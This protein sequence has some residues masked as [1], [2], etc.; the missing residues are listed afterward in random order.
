MAIKDLLLTNLPQ[1]C[2]TLASGKQACFRP[3]LVSEEKALL[4]AKHSDNKQS[5]LKTLVSMVNACFDLKRDVSICDFENM[6]LLLRA[7]SVGET[8]AFKI[9]CPET[10]ESV[11]IAINL[12]TD[13]TLSKGSVSNKIKLNENLLLILKEPT[14][15]TLI[16]YPE[17]TTS[18]EEMYGFIGSCMKEIQTSKESLDCT[19]LSEK[20]LK[21]FIKNLTSSQYKSV[22]SYF[23]NLPQLQVVANYK[24]SDGVQREAKIKGLFNYISFFLTI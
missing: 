12:M 10:G 14:I 1:Y 6:F 11:D 8:E 19:E 7:K 9:K 23:D 3:F 5:I 2:E 13:I 16:K 18:T 20:E 21:D 22:I 24:T 17:Y 4:L 15:K